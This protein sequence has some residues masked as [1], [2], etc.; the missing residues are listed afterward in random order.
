MVV[1][2]ASDTMC[3][4]CATLICQLD[5]LEVDARTVKK[6]LMGYIAAKYQ[7]NHKGISTLQSTT[8]S[9]ICVICQA[10]SNT[11]LFY[12]QKYVPK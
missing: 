4:R 2:G 12:F 11:I 1:V 9:D 7:L 10:I 6:T 3:A 5:K 8:S